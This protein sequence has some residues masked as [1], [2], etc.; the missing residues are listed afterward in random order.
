MRQEARARYEAGMSYKEA[1][2]DIALGVF[3]DWGDRERIVINC[4]TMFHEFGAQDKAE[5]TELFTGMAEY[6][7]ARPQEKS[8]E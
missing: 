8:A 4:A 3:D 1:A 2:F 6:A 5:I 7:K